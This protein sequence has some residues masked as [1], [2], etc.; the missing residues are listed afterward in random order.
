LDGCG[1]RLILGADLVEAPCEHARVTSIDAAGAAPPDQHASPNAVALDDGA[2]VVTV[3]TTSV[4]LGFAQ[5]LEPTHARE[6]EASDRARVADAHARPPA[7][8]SRTT[9]HE[10]RAL[11][12]SSFSAHAVQNGTRCSTVAGAAGPR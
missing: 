10:R 7:H 5:R 8:Q 11:R 4:G 12:P 3:R 1:G 9:L 6:A 2:E